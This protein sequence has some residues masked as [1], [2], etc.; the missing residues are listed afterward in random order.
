MNVKISAIK[1]GG[2]VIAPPGKSM[3]HRALICS[4]LTA[5]TSTLHGIIPS[6][7]MRATMRALTLLG[8][9][10]HYDEKSHKAEVEGVF[11]NGGSFKVPTKKINCGESGS[12]LRFLIPIFSLNNA[13]NVFCGSGKLMQRSQSVYQN[14]FSQ[15]GLCF[16]QTPDNITVD[17]ALLAGDYTVN[18]NVSS[19]FISGLIFALSLLKDDSTITVAPPFESENYVHL[20]LQVMQSFGV[21]IDFVKPYTFKIKG[22]QNYK[23]QNYTV[24]GDYSQAA[25]FAVLAATGGKKITIRNI[26]NNTLQGDA[27]IFDILKNCGAVIEKHSDY[28]TVSHGECPLKAFEADIANCPDLGPILMVLALFCEGESVLKNASRLRDKESDRIAAMQCEVHKIG[29]EIRASENEVY[30]KGTRQTLKSSD[31]LS[32]HNDHRIVMA[33][34]VACAEIA[35]KGGGESEISDAQAVEKSYPNFFEHLNLFL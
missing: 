26:Q 23:A 15:K 32:S 3:A 4:A 12:T 27:V 22:G 7:D 17:G 10:I 8:A 25:F 1:S 14:L 13:K 31:E 11:A 9:K 24:F 21:N 2:E 35:A 33:M 34:S 19:Q 30:I 6:E 20:S 29:G 16:C 18:G 28:I 5:G